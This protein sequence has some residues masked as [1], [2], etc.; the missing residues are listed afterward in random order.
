MDFTRSPFT[1]R[2][3]KG[4]HALSKHMDAENKDKLSQ[5]I[6]DSGH[7]QVLLLDADCLVDGQD[8]LGIDDTVAIYVTGACSLNWK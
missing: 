8:I 5:Q 3:D 1:E 6:A 2:T 4:V 7:T